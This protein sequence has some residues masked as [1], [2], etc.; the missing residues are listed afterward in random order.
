[1]SLTQSQI[2]NELH[3]RLCSFVKEETLLGPHEQLNFRTTQY[4]LRIARELEDLQLN[5]KQ[6]NE[7]LMS[8]RDIWSYNE[9]APPRAQQDLNQGFYDETAPPCAG[10]DLSD[11]FYYD[12]WLHQKDEQEHMSL[13]SEVATSE[14]L[15]AEAEVQQVPYAGEHSEITMGQALAFASKIH[16]DAYQ[17]HISFCEALSASSKALAVAADAVTRA[18]G[19]R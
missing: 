7:D 13:P 19:N 3:Q 18:H 2:I 5:E 4:I 12:D 6:A 10:H 14:Q 9:T 1:M 8:I 17:V 15:M 16:A 11:G